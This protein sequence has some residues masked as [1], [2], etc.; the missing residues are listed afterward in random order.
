MKISRRFVP[1]F[2]LTPQHNNLLVTILI[3]H[4][5]KKENPI[6]Y[7]QDNFHEIRIVILSSQIKLEIIEF[8]G[9]LR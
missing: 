1:I 7:M 8:F 5:R 9:N 4:N 2:V 3:S 6:K